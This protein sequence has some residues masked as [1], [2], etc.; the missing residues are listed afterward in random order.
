[1]TILDD[2]LD[3][4]TNSSVPAPD[5]VRKVQI[6]AQRLGATDIAAWARNEVSGYPAAGPL[7]GYRQMHTSVIGDFRDDFGRKFN[8]ALDVKPPKTEGWWIVQL[9]QPLL[10]IQAL[11][12]SD[13]EGAAQRPWTFQQVKLYE[14]AH[15]FGFEDFELFSAWNEITKQSLLGIVDVV[16]SRAMEFALDLQAKFPTAGEQGGPTIASSP[17]LAQTVYNITN[18]IIG[19]G[20]NVATGADAHQTST[21]N[22]GDEG[23]LLARLRELGFGNK[24][25]D[26]FVAAIS[27]EKS[28]DGPKTQSFLRRVGSGAVSLVS[29]VTSAATVEILVSLAKSYLGIH[30]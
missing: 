18:N 21:V 10:E 27:E 24:E 7:P 6:A 13:G 12:N 19:D 15:L 2:I 1:M 11:A 22:K 4:S 20:T 28:L 29:G 26:E 16:R 9:R 30:G 23:A 25:S 8:H 5:L 3:A 17:G 14:K